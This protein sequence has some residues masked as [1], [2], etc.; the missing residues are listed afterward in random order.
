MALVSFYVCIYMF[1]DVNEWR[2]ELHTFDF[3]IPIRRDFEALRSAGD[4][5][6]NTRKEE[7]GCGDVEDFHFVFC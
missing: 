4:A 7:E 6:N 2:S 1:V 5:G 3:P